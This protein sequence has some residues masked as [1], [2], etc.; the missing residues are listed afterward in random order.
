MAFTA[1]YSAETAAFPAGGR[2]FR[3]SGGGIT[4]SSDLHG[5]ADMDLFDDSAVV[6]DAIYFTRGANQQSICGLKF[7]IGAALSTGVSLV[8]EYYKWKLTGSLATKAWASIEDLQDDTAGFTVLGV[9]T[10]R[11]PQ[12][13]Q[14]TELAVNGVTAYWVRC[15]ISAVAVPVTEGGRNQTNAVTF[16]RGT[17]TISGTSDAAPGSFTDIY[18][19]LITNKPYITVNK[20]GDGIFDFTKVGLILNSRVKTTNETILLGQNSLENYSAG[21]NNFSFI[22]SGTKKGSRGYDGSTFFVYGIHNS[23]VFSLGENSKLYG[24]IIKVGKVG[25]DLH[26]YG[27]YAGILGEIVDCFIEL[28]PRFSSGILTN[29]R[30]TGNFILVGDLTATINGFA[31]ICSAP[32]MFYKYGTFIGFTI[33]GFDWQF[34]GTGS[35][36]V[37]L[38]SYGRRSDETLNFL[39]PATPLPKFAD[40]IKPVAN[41]NAVSN[42]TAMKVYNAAAGIYTDYTVQASNVTAD[43]VPLWGEVGDILYFCSINQYSLNLSFVRT[44]AVNDYEYTWEWHDGVSWVALTP[45]FWDGT[46]NLSSTG[47]ILA[48]TYGVTPNKNQT[49]DGVAGYWIRARITK[50]G[51]GEPKATQI[52]YISISGV[53]GWKMCQKYSFDAIVT[54]ASGVA[55]VGAEVSAIYS[56]GTVAFTATTDANGAIVQQWMINAKYEQD[57]AATSATYYIKETIITTAVL[58]IKKSGYETYTGKIDITKLNSL[59]IALKRSQVQ[60]DQEA[61]L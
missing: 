31:Y 37:W 15:R 54:D 34:S 46:N 44:G 43:D 13:W 49:I 41:Y 59:T 39:N 5:V 1:T 42:L 10:V 56:D 60:I 18:D 8:W 3:A 23:S 4:F 7:N 51:T 19:W 17:V 35:V 2:I 61:L 29:I 45:Y 6:G 22:E 32:Q 52:R 57:A 58:T 12:Q 55:I 47:N 48:S 11:F 28:S 27:G 33:T 14:P 9:N 38:Y 24:S 40:S 26:F 36:I 50:K 25:G 16:G 53:G 30:T 20:F 21:L